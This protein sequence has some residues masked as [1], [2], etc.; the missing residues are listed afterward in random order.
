M[1]SALSLSVVVIVRDGA[2]TLDRA[3][4]A[5]LASELPRDDYELIVVD[6]ASGDASATIGARYA[7]T[8]V[9]LTGRPSGPAYTRNRGAD[10]ARGEVVAFVD[11][12]AMVQPD[13]LPGM[14]EML[15]R[16]PDL[17]AIAAS[18]DETPAAPN[19]ASQY[20]NLLLHFGQDRHVAVEGDFASGCAAIRRSVLLTIGMYDEWRFGTP[21]LESVELGKRLKRAGH[22]VLLSRKLKVTQLKRWSLLSISREVWNRSSLLARSFGYQRTRELAPTEV[23]FTLSRTATPALAVVCTIFLCSAFFAEPNAPTAASIAG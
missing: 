5:I 14:L 6:D 19:F 16:Y 2:S 7:D 15:T 18:R 9:R 23:V 12:D 21:C 10:L 8:V 1:N 4:T 11:C 20:W 22:G 17:D 13:T 3:L